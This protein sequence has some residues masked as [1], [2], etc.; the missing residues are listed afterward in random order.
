MAARK[1]AKPAQ[2]MLA[3]EPESKPIDASVRW[4]DVQGRRETAIC[5]RGEK[6]WNCVIS[7]FPI[8]V[9]TLSLREGDRADPVKFGPDLYPVKRAVARLRELQEKNGITW[10]AHRL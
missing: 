10:G 5:F 7:D 1:L 8:R 9:Y 2:N 4:V 3:A 6:F